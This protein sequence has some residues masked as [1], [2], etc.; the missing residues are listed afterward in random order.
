M[1]RRVL[2]VVLA[3]VFGGMPTSGQAQSPVQIK[4]NVL[5][6]AVRDLSPKAVLIKQASASPAVAIADTATAVLRAGEVILAVDSTIR[7]MPSPGNDARQELGVRGIAT[8]GGAPVEFH[9]VVE[10]GT[11]L[12]YSAQARR[13]VGTVSLGLENNDHSS[14]SHVLSTP[15]TLQ[16]FGADH[17]APDTVVL[18]HTS[19]P[20]TKVVLGADGVRDSLGVKVRAAGAPAVGF[21][22]PVRRLRLNVSPSAR[23]V[24]GL[25]VDEVRVVVP[26]PAEYD[27]DTLTV[28]LGNGNVEARPSALT[29]VRGQPAGE[30][31]IRSIGMGMRTLRV[32]GDWFI[33]PVPL[34]LEFHPPLAFIVFSFAGGVAG[35]II[36][37]FTKGKHRNPRRLAEGAFVGAMTGF[38]GAVLFVNGVNLLSANLRTGSSEFIVFVVSLVCGW[39]GD[40]VLSVLAGGM[41][42]PKE[43]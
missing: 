20:F 28:T 40:A 25:G 33:E 30:A 23:E 15:V 38:V 3:S 1:M 11:P 5:R 27:G 37:V 29:L 43:A 18:R 32:E 7:P 35:A 8:S 9:V 4:S 19:V 2:L 10:P 13:V 36:R 16:L 12:R 21:H 34:T 22:V 24:S 26:F 39:L 31:S 42:R 41:G 14:A 17:I 6:R